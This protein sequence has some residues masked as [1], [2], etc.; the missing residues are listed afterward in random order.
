[1]Y[2]APGSLTVDQ[3]ARIVEG[4][5]VDYMIDVELPFF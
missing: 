1:M 2:L 5:L 3:R 4:G